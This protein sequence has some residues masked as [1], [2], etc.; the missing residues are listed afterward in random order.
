MVGFLG[1]IFT[2]VSERADTRL[3]RYFPC[4]ALVGG[5]NLD[6]GLYSL[7][8]NFYGNGGLIGSERKENI[9][10]RENRLNFEEFVCLK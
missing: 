10:V 8:V 3:S 9:S 5:I 7:T 1:R 6:P 2:E 4:Y